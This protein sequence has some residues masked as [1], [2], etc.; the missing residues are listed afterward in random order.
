MKKVGLIILLNSMFANISFK[1]QINIAGKFC[2]KNDLLITKFYIVSLKG[3][4]D[5]ESLRNNIIH[6]FKKNNIEAIVNIFDSKT[7]RLIEELNK[8]TLNCFTLLKKVPIAT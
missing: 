2:E 4:K 6:D 3:K 7:D 5:I 1:D 8:Q